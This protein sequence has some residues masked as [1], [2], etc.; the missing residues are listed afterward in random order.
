MDPL[1]RLTLAA[2]A[3]FGLHAGIAGSA[4]RGALMRRLGERAFLGLFSLLSLAS[5][6]WLVVA[7]RGAPCAPL[8][9]VPAWCRW[10]PVVVMPAACLLLVGAFSAPNPGAVRGEALLEREFA[11]QGVLRITRHP[12]LWAVVLWSSSHILA[13]GD[14][15]GSLFFG[16]LGLTAALGM[17]H[18][19]RKRAQARPEAFA[20]YR[21]LTSTLPFLAVAQGRNALVW[22]EFKLPVGLGVLLLVALIAL[23]R[24]LFHVPPLP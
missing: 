20:R 17:S 4:L 22:R 21:A 5:L 6:S 23:H 12:F 7:F 15:A 9:I 16:T 3:W 10:L 1:V 14:L 19:D 2:L 24:P 18:I 13:N 11:A 8:W